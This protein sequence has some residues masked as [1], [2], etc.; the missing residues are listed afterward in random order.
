MK[1]NIKTNVYYMPRVR[2]GSV[3]VPG[4]VAEMIAPN[5]RQSVNDH[6]SNSHMKP[7]IRPL[8]NSIAYGT[9]NTT[10]TQ[11]HNEIQSKNNLYLVNVD[12]SASTEA[13]LD[14]VCQIAVR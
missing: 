9:T 8:N 10:L 2:E 5:R 6:E 4:S 13:F 12:V 1:E 7:N 11:F 3:S 14:T